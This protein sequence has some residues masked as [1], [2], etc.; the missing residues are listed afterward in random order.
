MSLREDSLR[1]DSIQSLNEGAL[2]FRDGGSL[3]S[4]RE[5]SPTYFETEGQGLGLGLRGRDKG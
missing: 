5:G 4:V 1:E 3:Q 2:H